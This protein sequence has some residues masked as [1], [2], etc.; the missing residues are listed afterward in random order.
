VFTHREAQTANPYDSPSAPVYPTAISEPQAYE[1]GS[2]PVIVIGG[3][4]FIF[5]YICSNVFAIADLY[6]VGLGTYGEF[7]PSPL[8]SAF[9]SPL[10]L[11][12]IYALAAAAVVAGCVL[13]GCQNYHPAAVVC[14]ILC[15]LMGLVFAVGMPLR[16]AWRYAVPA[17]TAYVGVG[18]CLA[19]A[20]VM[21]LVNLYG[22]LHVGFEPIVASLLV[23]AGLAMV[24]GGF[25]KL[26]HSGA[27]SQPP[28][29]AVDSVGDAF[30]AR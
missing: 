16:S 9:N 6:H 11:W 24:V 13:I 23:E 18:T 15:P 14:F 25:L 19:G 21:H 2:V 7:V 5:G 28:A 8:S 1:R 12:L 4:L 10:E 22:R 20:G 27:F 26:V 30:P 29:E 17:A 3:V